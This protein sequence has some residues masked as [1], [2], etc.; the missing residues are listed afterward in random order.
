MPDRILKAVE[1]MP[2]AV[3]QTLNGAAV[4]TSFTSI[5]VEQIPI[6]A[7]ALSSVWLLLQIYTWVERR[8][9]NRKKKDEYRNDT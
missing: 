8:V 6:V 5:F 2:T 7:A 4:T 9:K 1:Q 3:S